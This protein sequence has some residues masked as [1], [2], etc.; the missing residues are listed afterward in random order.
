MFGMWLY[1]GMCHGLFLLISA[2]PWLH[3]TAN[4]KFFWYTTEACWSN[5]ATMHMQHGSRWFPLASGFLSLFRTIQCLLSVSFPRGESIEKAELQRLQPGHPFPEQ[6]RSSGVL[7]LGKRRCF[8]YHFWIC[9]GCV[10]GQE[11]L[12]LLL[13]QTPPKSMM[14]YVSF[15]DVEPIF[16]HILTS[17]SWFWFRF[18]PGPVTTTLGFIRW[19]WKAV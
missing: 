9:Q 14:K 4:W 15:F 5:N 11:C 6:W 2:S 10:A 19:L 12:H 7:E 18:T 16:W 8:F 17:A 1:W 13:G 3:A